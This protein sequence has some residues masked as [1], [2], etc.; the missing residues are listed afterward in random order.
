MDQNLGWFVVHTQPLKELTARDNLSSQGYSVFLP[1]LQKTI[2]HARKVD[3]VLRPLFP[4][5]LFVCLDLDRDQ[6]R[7]INGTVGVAYIMTNNNKPIKIRTS[8]VESLKIDLSEEGFLPISSLCHFMKGD[9]V[10]IIDGIFKGHEAIF[11]KVSDKERVNVLLTFMGREM[12]MTLP[13]YA[14]EAA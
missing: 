5:Y 1:M 6:W 8:V 14:V 9:K 12:N 7:S 11:S 4:R 3:T 10:D 13:L 2:K